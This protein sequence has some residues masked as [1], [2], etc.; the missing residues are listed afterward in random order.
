[1][2]EGA[3]SPSAIAAL[4]A[5]LSD[6]LRLTPW[7][8]LAGDEVEARFGATTQVGLKLEL[9]Q[10]TGSFKARGALAVMEALPPEALARGVTAVSAGNHAIAV[11]WAAKRLGTTA[12]V[13]MPK[14]ASPVRV[15]RC[16][17]LGAQVELVPDVTVAFDR[18]QEVVT[19]EGRTFVHPF[20]GPNTALGTATLGAELLEQAAAE[21]PR[22]GDRAA[23][24]DAVI[25]P[26]G[27]GGLAGGVAAAVKQLHPS[28]A[29]YGVEPV[30]AD[31]MRRS[32]DRGAPVAIERV[33]TIADSLGSP[34]AEPY[35]FGL[36]RRFVDDVVMVDDDDLRSAMRFMAEHARL[37]VEPAAAAGAA[38]LAG[39]LRERLDGRRVALIVC[40][41]NLDLETYQ[42]YLNSSGP[43]I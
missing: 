39:P 11:A 29:V 15:E 41:T 31:S 33:R 34:R 37:F 21:W 32:L 5:R 8:R 25:V 6:V 16:R 19:T 20:E 40:G 12:T 10:H 42:R 1:M 38:A 13:V 14:T 43:T 24:P 36:V 2:D 27:G 3:P 4:R 35:S 18:V 22:T 28:C 7:W 17:A 26:I 30:G 23:G 9:F